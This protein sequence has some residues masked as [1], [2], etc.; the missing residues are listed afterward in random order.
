MEVFGMAVVGIVLGFL[1]S[2][3][4]SSAIIYLAARLLKEKEGFGTAVLAALAG[5]LIF[6]FVSYLIGIGLVAALVGGIVWL[7]ALGNLY[8]IGW[9]KSFI[10][11]VVIWIFAAIV[12]LALPTIAG[13]L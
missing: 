2:L 8:K 12:S 5:A 10:I 1:I 4:I 13:P 6:A 3:I 7:I 9:L 11:T